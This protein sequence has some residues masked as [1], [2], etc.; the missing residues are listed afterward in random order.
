MWALD[1][2][3]DAA[4]LTASVSISASVPVPMVGNPG[5]PVHGAFGWLC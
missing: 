2:F 1:G 5:P 4:V 3:E